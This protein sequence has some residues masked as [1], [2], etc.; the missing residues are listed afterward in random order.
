MEPKPYSSAIPANEESGKDTTIEDFAMPPGDGPSRQTAMAWDRDEVHFGWHRDFH[1][2]RNA[3]KVLDHVRSTAS[4]IE[5]AIERVR[6]YRS[7]VLVSDI[8]A[9]PANVRRSL[10]LR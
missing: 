10:G 9:L 6:L 3:M 5:D 8:D 2:R 7:L 4:A 1:A